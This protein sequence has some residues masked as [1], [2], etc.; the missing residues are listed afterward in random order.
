MLLKLNTVKLTARK[1]L[2]SLT[3][4]LMLLVPAFLPAQ[5]VAQEIESLLEQSAVTYAQA[6]R[7]VLDAADVLSAGPVEAFLFAQQQGWLPGNA[8]ADQL[9]RLDGLSLLVMRAFDLRGGLMFQLTGSPRHAYREL[10]Q[11]SVIQGRAAPNMNVT[12]YN[13]LFIINRAITITE[14]FF[15][16]NPEDLL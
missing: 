5:S 16:W 14:E 6:A 15:D 8:E 2:V 4:C 10:I 11:N 13:L 1:K 12:G 9:A 7:F 3:F